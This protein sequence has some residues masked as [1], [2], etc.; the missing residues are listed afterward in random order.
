[1]RRNRRTVLHCRGVLEKRCCYFG[2]SALVAAKRD[3][4]EIEQNP[5]QPPTRPAR[6]KLVTTPA[7]A[8]ACG[9]EWTILPS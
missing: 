3:G 9:D 5:L 6:A 4:L 2:M 1:M 7:T 8:A